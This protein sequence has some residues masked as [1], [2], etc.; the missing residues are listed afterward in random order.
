MHWVYVARY[1]VGEGGRSGGGRSCRNAFCEKRPGAA[2][3]WALPVPVSFRGDPLLTKAELI[4]EVGGT[5]L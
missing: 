1:R 3:W 2:L 5:L 4:T